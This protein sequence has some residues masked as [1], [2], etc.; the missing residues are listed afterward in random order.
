M[1]ESVE[2]D[3]NGIGHAN[4]FEASFCGFL[5]VRSSLD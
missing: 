5:I 1:S 3:V 2:S 4:G